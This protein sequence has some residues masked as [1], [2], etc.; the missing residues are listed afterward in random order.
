MDESLPL[1]TIQEAILDFL[2]SRSD[3]VV[4]GAQAV[5]A[6]VPEPRMSQDIDL[7]AVG[8]EELAEALRQFLHERFHIAVRIRKVAGGKGLRLFQVR[9]E[10]NRHLVDIR[11]VTALPAFREIEQI[12]VIEPA[13]LIALKVIAF[14]QRRGQPKSGTDWRDIALLLL[15]FPDLKT[16]KGP[17][18]DKLAERKVSQEI[19]DAWIA[20]VNQDIQSEADEDEFW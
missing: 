16:L 11:A 13:D 2:R 12:Q 9:K 14:C 10:G 19:L 7:L 6:Y 20:F 15:A 18:A 4:F 3:A 17:V 5:N 1:A 8:A